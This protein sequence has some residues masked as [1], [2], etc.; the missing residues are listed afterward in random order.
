MH[1][2]P[3]GALHADS[4]WWHLFHKVK[5]LPKITNHSSY[6]MAVTEIVIFLEALYHSNS[7]KFSVRDDNQGQLKGQRSATFVL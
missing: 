5:S 4:P 1:K 3:K 2:D 6:S 7:T